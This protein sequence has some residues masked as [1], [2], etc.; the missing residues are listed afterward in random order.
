MIELTRGGCAARI[1]PEEGAVAASL[2]VSGHDVLSTTRVAGEA[3]RAR[4]VA[5]TEDDWVRAWRGG[6]QLC[7]PTAGQADTSAAIAQGFHGVA[8]Q[9]AWQVLA[10]DRTRA[11]LAWEGDRIGARR[12]WTLHEDGLEA[13]TE[14]WNA[15]PTPRRVAIA[16]HLVLGQDVLAG[17]L[18]IVPPEGTRVAP[19]DYAGHPAGDALAWPGEADEAWASVDERTP[20]RVAAL[21]V[22]VPRSLGIRGD[23]VS[24]EV[25]WEGDAFAHALL[26]EELGA[27][28]D[29]PWD[30]QV[31][32]LG[33][34]P[35][36]TPHG[37]GTAHDV[38]ILELAPGQHIR[39]SCRLRVRW[40]E[41]DAA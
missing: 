41:G 39:W 26:W 6:W 22:P 38:G 37:A 24:V 36:T 27:T 10:Q 1:L 33:I 23:H 2:R 4:P 3:E 29:P 18:E 20:A 35:T 15:G 34:E 8:S 32:A 7:F 9:A 30:G 31:H 28:P 21:T 16:E 25:S 5:V 11:W 40:Q 13:R 14:A 19:L 12:N 17:A